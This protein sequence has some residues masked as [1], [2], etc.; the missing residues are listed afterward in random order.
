MKW[1]QLACE[2]RETTLIHL[3]VRWDWDTHRADSRFQDL[4]RRLGLTN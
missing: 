4:L 2:Q 3:G 1:L